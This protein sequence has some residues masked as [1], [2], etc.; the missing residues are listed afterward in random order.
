MSLVDFP[1]AAV[2]EGD[3]SSVVEYLKQK[4][5]INVTSSFE[6]EEW[7]PL[8]LAAAEGDTA[9]VILLLGLGA[10]VDR[11]VVSKV[12]PGHTP[13]HVACRY[14]NASVAAELLRAGASP[15]TR[16]AHGMAPL[17]YAASG[18]YNDLLNMLLEAGASPSPTSAG[19]ATPLHF[20]EML[21]RDGAVTALKGAI[22]L[23][24]GRRPIKAWLEALACDKYVANF[25]GAGYDDLKFIADHGLT[26]E[27]LDCVG[28]PMS[29]LG[30]RRKLM[31]LHNI[32]DFLEDESEKEGSGDESGDDAEDGSGSEAA[33]GE[34]SSEEEGDDSESNSDG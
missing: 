21:G 4:S 18:G 6:S 10:Q 8:H 31:A 30:L 33:S 34:E 15:D 29:K 17:H 13:L 12:L 28:V 27:D 26:A 11:H 1:F 20:A 16:D 25:L 2:R 5:S 3:E 32:A 19:G 23:E 7:S 9:A 14:G 22:R 24:E